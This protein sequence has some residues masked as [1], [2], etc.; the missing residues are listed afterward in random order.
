MHPPAFAFPARASCLE[1][2]FASFVPV[3]IGTSSSSF[4]LCGLLFAARL[5]SVVVRTS[6]P[7][8]CSSL[9][10]SRR[11]S[12]GLSPA[13]PRITGTS[14]SCCSDLGVL[15]LATLLSTREKRLWRDTLVPLLFISSDRARRSFGFS[16]RLRL[17]WS[18]LASLLS[19][20]DRA[21]TEEL[22]QFQLIYQISAD[23]RS[24]I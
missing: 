7:S 6:L 18:M 9:W 2:L 22:S 10:L 17:S 23:S 20:S 12:S 19:D 14:S 16:S 5:F 8:S 24:I 11:S 1:G 4:F 13:R 21:E 15:S 3:M